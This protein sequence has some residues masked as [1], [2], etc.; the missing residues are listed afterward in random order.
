MKASGGSVVR[1]LDS[2][3]VRENGLERLTNRLPA[4]IHLIERKRWISK[5]RRV[6]NNSDVCE[7]PISPRKVGFTPLMSD[8]VS[9][10]S[11]PELWLNDFLDLREKD[12]SPNRPS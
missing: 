5:H 8:R 9:L 1:L 10:G 12:L 11:C 7:T 3:R 2:A 6:G 4:T